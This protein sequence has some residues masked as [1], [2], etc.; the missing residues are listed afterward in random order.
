MAAT[1]SR[2]IGDPRGDP[3]N[4]LTTFL[5]HLK[6]GHM[7]QM[8]ETYLPALCQLLVGVEGPEESDRLCRDLREIVGSIVLLA[9]PLSPISLSQLLQIAKRKID[10]QLR[11]LTSVISVPSDPD[12]SITLI[13]LSFREFLVKKTDYDR[14]RPFAINDAASHGYQI[15]RTLLDAGLN[16]DSLW[17]EYSNRFFDYG[18]TEVLIKTLGCPL[19][20]SFRLE[21]EVGQQWQISSAFYLVRAKDEALNYV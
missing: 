3:H 17:I 10:H 2:F 6:T 15:I 20:R 1:I 21:I 16:P 12:A 4:R 8:E 5:H 7:T 13:H 18:C 14:A 19:T 9:N 11:L